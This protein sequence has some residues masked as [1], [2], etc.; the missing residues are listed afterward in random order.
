MGSL[1]PVQPPP[2]AK[3]FVERQYKMAERTLECKRHDAFE[4]WDLIREMKG[5]T[6]RNFLGSQGV[7]GFQTFLKR[8]Y[9][10]VLAGWR[11]MDENGDGRLTRGEFMDACAKIGFHGDIKFVWRELDFKD[12][13]VVGLVEIDHNA[14]FLIGE[15]KYKLMKK[16]GS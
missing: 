5:S 3:A 9:G 13:G 1:P 10:S 6:R 11:E 16:Y 8:K 2:S 15:F 14:G 12:T 7:R 4:T